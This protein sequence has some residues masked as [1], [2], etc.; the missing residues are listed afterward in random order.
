MLLPYL[1]TWRSRLEGSDSPLG[2]EGNRGTFDRQLL[3]ELNDLSN[4]LEKIPGATDLASVKE[5][6]AQVLARGKP[7]GMG[8]GVKKCQSCGRDIP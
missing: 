4:F 1:E 5:E 8:G 2:S 3:L 7:V 6:L